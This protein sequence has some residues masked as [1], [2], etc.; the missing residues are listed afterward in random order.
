M[1]HTMIDLETLGTEPGSV[2]LSIAAV[3]FDIDSKGNLFTVEGYEAHFYE[4]ISLKSAQKAGLQISEDTLQWWLTQKPEIMA[5]M[6]E[7]TKPLKEVLG[8]FREWK[9]LNEVFYFWGNSARFDM[10][11]L[12]AGYHS[13]GEKIP[14]NHRCEMD[15]RTMKNL[16]PL[17]N[18]ESTVD[19]DQAHNPIADCYYQIEKLHAIVKT[20]GI[21]FE[22]C[23]QAK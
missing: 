19:K 12:E 8:L 14:W 21:N 1:K 22:F 17:D 11:L 20:Y 18:F 7:F 2:F 3:Q 13:V 16:F 10:G 5:K 9:S 4:N 15:Y 23:T 6:F